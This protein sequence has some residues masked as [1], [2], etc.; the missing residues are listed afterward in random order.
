MRNRCGKSTDYGGRKPGWPTIA[1]LF[2]ATAL[3]VVAFVT[4]LV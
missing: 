2:L 4:K 1:L 3:L